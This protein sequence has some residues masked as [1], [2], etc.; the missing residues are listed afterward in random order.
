MYHYIMLY[1]SLIVVHREY[2]VRVYPAKPSGPI[3]PDLYAQMDTFRATI[4]GTSRETC[5][6]HTLHLCTCSRRTILYRLKG[7]CYSP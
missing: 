7:T 1:M 6:H 2:L 5:G 3:R 4:L